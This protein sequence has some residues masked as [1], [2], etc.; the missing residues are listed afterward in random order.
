MSPVWSE[1]IIFYLDTEQIDRYYKYFNVWERYMKEKKVSETWMAPG[2][3]CF[4][5]WRCSMC[6]KVAS[7]APR[8]DRA[9]QRLSQEGCIPQESHTV[10]VS[11]SFGSAAVPVSQTSY[12]KP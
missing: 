5:T 8:Q 4:M 2:I 1:P 12:W 6:R 10:P 7:P 3:N 9:A 11:L